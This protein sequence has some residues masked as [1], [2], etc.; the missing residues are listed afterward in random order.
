MKNAT[1][2][3]VKAYHEQYYIN[4]TWLLTDDYDTRIETNI[5]DIYE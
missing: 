2:N 4:G 1:Y 3:T 5:T